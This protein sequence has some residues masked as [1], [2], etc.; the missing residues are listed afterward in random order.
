MNSFH[1]HIFHRKHFEMAAI[2][3]G[4]I[5]FSGTI[6][7]TLEGAKTSSKKKTGTPS[8]KAEKK[9]KTVGAKEI[10]SEDAFFERVWQQYEVGSDKEKKQAMTQLKGLL[11]KDPGNG[12]AHYYL[13]IMTSQEGSASTAEEHLRS[14]LLAFPESEDILFRLGEVLSR[15]KKNSEE[16]VSLF[17]KTLSLNPN[18]GGA[19]S[20]LGL[21]ALEEG[22]LPKAIELLTKA[23]QFDPE[24][25]ATYQGLG[26]ALFVS[27]NP[28]DALEPLKKAIVFDESDGDSHF[29]LGKSY[30]ALGK[31]KEASEELEKAKK[32]GRKDVELKGKVGYDL[33]AALYDLGK[34]EEAIKEYQSAIRTAT[35][36][37]IGWFE[38]GKIEETR[39][40]LDKAMS[41]FKKAYE[42]DKKMSE[43][44]FRIGKILRGEKKLKDAIASFEV[45][46]KKKDDWAEKAKN[47]I[48]E[49]NAL[50]TE[51]K[52][53]QLIEIAT[54]GT[55]KEREKAL[56]ALLEI[57]KKDRFALEGLRDFYRETGNFH[58]S[59]TFILEL[60]QAGHIS[61]E[62]AKIQ[63]AAL[64]T[65]FESGEDLAELETR[66]EDARQH[67][68]WKTAVELNQR[69]LEEAKLQLVMIQTKNK[70][71][72]DIHGKERLI[73]L[74]K[75]RIKKIKEDMADFKRE[76]DKFK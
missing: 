54:T 14:A 42:L 25:R 13:G 36:P 24:N 65:R 11:K 73:K 32:L 6:S 45:I 30:E 52:R 7:T 55:E 21:K 39:G 50:I 18:N 56:F 38:I 23:A 64:Q 43:A 74:T 28:A 27:N 16:A 4:I 66:L 15:K 40:F 29:Y 12:M 53:E 61:Q 46:A 8:P 70:T 48:E 67:G 35:A 76:R 5:F 49:I 47:E 68:D 10:E 62:E 72:G 9:K 17:E 59:K 69:L 20:F 37:A 3:L 33:A 34:T 26:K 57:D 75:L 71:R 44:Q 63:V 51:D 2:I 60:K 1:P 58:K 31:V 41:A 22:D 19:L